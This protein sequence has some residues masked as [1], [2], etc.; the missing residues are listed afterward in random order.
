MFVVLQMHLTDS[1]LLN[2]VNLFLMT[3][4]YKLKILKINFIVRNIVRI[5]SIKVNCFKVNDMITVCCD[6]RL[7]SLLR[8]E[9]S[10]DKFTRDRNRKKDITT[11]SFSDL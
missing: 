3:Y 7:H 6:E 1:Y 4:K 2:V 8:P 11:K 5:R 10:L 9:L